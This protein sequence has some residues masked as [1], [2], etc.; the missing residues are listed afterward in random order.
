MALRLQQIQDHIDIGGKRIGRIE[1]RIVERLGRAIENGGDRVPRK[2][3]IEAGSD[4]GVVAIEMAATAGQSGFQIGFV[5][6]K[7]VVDHDHLPGATG[8]QPIHQVA[9]DESGAAGNQ[10]TLSQERRP[11]AHA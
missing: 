2:N 9:A 5:A 11:G 3:V 6:E 10:N 8:Q 1:E 7:Q 4:L